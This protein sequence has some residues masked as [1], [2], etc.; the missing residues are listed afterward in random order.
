[1]ALTITIEGKGVIAN[2]DSIASDTAGGSWAEDGLGT[3]SLSTETYLYGSSCVA[4]AYSNKAGWSYYDIG[5]GNELDFTPTTGTEAGQFIYMWIFFPTPGLGETVANGGFTIRIGNDASNYRDYMVSASDNL[6][7]WYGDWRCFVI[8]PTKSGTVADTGTFNL[9]SVRRF[10]C[11]V[12]ATANAKGDNL[13]IDQISVGSGLRI[14]GTSTTGWK[15]IVDYCTDYPNRA[16]GMMQEREGI[17]YI[18]GN[19]YIGDST[20]Q[21]ANVSFTD[22]ARILQFG[23]TEYYSGTAWVTTMPTTANGITIEDHTS[24]TTTFSD[25]VIVG[26]DNGRSGS[27]II[28]NTN[29]NVSLDLY[30]GNNTGSITTLYGTTIKDCSGSINSG[31]DS[32]HK[33]YGC[34]FVG[35]NQFDPVGAPVIRNCTFAELYD[36][37]TGNASKNSALLWNSNIN[38]QNCNFIANNHSSTDIAHGIEHDAAGSVTYTNLYFSGNEVDVH[39]SATT[40]DLTIGIAGGDTPTYTDDS[41][42]TVTINNAKTV[43]LS[44]VSE[45]TA[46]KIIANETVGTITSGDVIVEAFADST[47]EAK[48]T[49]FNYEAAFD[50][51]GLDVLVRARNSGIAVAAIADDGGVFTDETE[52]A[53]SNSTADMTLLPAIPALNDAYYFGHNEQFNQLKLV[54]STV[55]THTVQPTITWE[56]YNGTGWSSLTNVSDGTSGYET[57]GENVVSYTLPGNWATTTINSQGPLYYIRARLSTVGTITQVPVGT[58]TT[59]DTTR[60]LPYFAER[61]ITSS[62]LFDIAAWTEDTIGKF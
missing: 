20:N 53:S 19:I 31:N 12:D 62:G 55:L 41:T 39:F 33:F 15:D 1:M 61:T 45:G 51:S 37:G 2:S 48:I 57:S 9:A 52:E 32:D 58:K 43:S 50:P 35:C 29:Q 60:Y 46:V 14:T 28:G 23:D 17:Y 49:N 30:G 27:T 7:G 10:G 26:S 18:Y 38:I 8:D 22:S 4:T 21:A 13:F 5:S 42:G 40:G 16:W 24:Y 44:G 54:I 25:G 3:M 59:L 6:N 36:D 11:Y 47:G 34:T 56:Y